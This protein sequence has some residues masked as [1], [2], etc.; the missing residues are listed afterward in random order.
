MTDNS[1]PRVALVSVGIGRRQRG[2]ERMFADLFMVL[3]DELDVTLFKSGG[4]C[5]CR[6]KIPRLLRP[7]TAIARALP[8][9]DHAGGRD[10]KAECLAYGLSLLPELLRHRFDV[11]HC[12]DPPLAH[13]LQRLKQACRLR[14]RVLFTEGCRVPPRFYPR[15]SHLHHVAKFAHDEAAT[16][17]IPTSC[18][19]VIPVGVDTRRFAT[20]VDRHALRRKHGIADSTF[21]LL[22]ISNV[23]RVFKRVDYIIEEVSRIEGDILLWIDGHPEDPT[24]P[25]L[26]RQKL[27]SRCRITYVPSSS[28]PELYQVA[29]LMIHASTN[30]AFGLAV[31]E[32][33]CSGL[34]VLAHD[35]P[36]FEW[37]LGHRDGLIDMSRAGIL[38]ARLK[39][40]SS[41]RDEI[42]RRAK[43]RAG[44]ACRRFDWHALVPA[45]VQM[46]QTVAARP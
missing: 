12:V 42:S 16:G 15:V 32:A 8:L 4:E 24:L 7:A 30:E 38:E 2:F 28:V 27:G 6:E 39:Q 37:L 3:R 26:A 14:A 46:Y 11:I 29:D 18:M 9:G 41:E 1:R 25:E 13:V 21:V 36:H 31:V 34:M 10:Y 20:R 45:Y 23:E 5:T 40:L 33:S 35:C 44:D 43:Q 22:V 19:T 17:G